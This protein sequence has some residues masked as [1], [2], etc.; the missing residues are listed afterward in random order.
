MNTRQRIQMQVDIQN[1]NNI[2]N[3]CP[4]SYSM[5]SYKGKIVHSCEHPKYKKECYME[6]LD[7][8]CKI[9]DWKEC[10]LNK[11]KGAFCLW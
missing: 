11:N 8:I 6:G 10:E 5:R 7:E 2:T 9:S 1:K 4:F 3:E